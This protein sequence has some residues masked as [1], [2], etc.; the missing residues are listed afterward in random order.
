MSEKTYVIQMKQYWYDDEGYHST[1]GK[2]IHSVYKDK[3]EAH[4]MLTKLEA[5]FIR[6]H[7]LSR[8]YDYSE[9]EGS[10][11]EAR[12]F[13]KSLDSIID[14]DE[15]SVATWVKEN[16]PYLEEKDLLKFARLLDANAYTLLEFDT[17][18]TFLAI[19]DQARKQYMSGLNSRCETTWLQYSESYDVIQGYLVA[20]YFGGKEKLVRKGELEHLSKTPLILKSLVDDVSHWAIYDENRK[21][22]RFKKPNKVALEKAGIEKAKTFKHSFVTVNAVLKNKFSEVH[23]L[24]LEQVLEIEKRLPSEFPY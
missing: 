16:S 18:P 9:P 22:L 13:A 14:V 1:L 17:E 15:V 12:H 2:R 23:E 21:K 6:E 11:E 20:N 8:V 24:T 7:N 5:Q 19:W 10:L 3:T 4:E